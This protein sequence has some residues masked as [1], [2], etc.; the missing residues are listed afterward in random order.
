MLMRSD[1]EVAGVA[2]REDVPRL[3]DTIHWVA[4]NDPQPQMR[5]L[6]AGYPMM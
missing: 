3:R 5:E 2:F 4:G 6:A 1:P